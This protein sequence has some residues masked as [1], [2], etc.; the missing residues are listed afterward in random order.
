M[1][2]PELTPLPWTLLSVP[3]KV[4]D[5]DAGTSFSESNPNSLLDCSY[6]VWSIV[7]RFKAFF[8]HYSKTFK[9][10]AMKEF[11]NR[12]IPKKYEHN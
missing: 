3:S 11:W 10:N 4:N 5:T 12:I 6:I 9:G 2:E 8:E 7:N 1:T